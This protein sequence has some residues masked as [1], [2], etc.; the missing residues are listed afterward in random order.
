MTPEWTWPYF[1][2]N[3]TGPWLSD[4]KFQSSVAHGRR[5]PNSKLDA[6]SRDHDTAYALSKTDAQRRKADRV[7]YRKTRDMSW[8][9]RLAG[10]IVLYGND[11]LLLLGLDRFPGAGSRSKVG[12]GINMGND[13]SRDV[14]EGEN[15]WTPKNHKNLREIMMDREGGRESMR[16]Y[17]EQTAPIC[18]ALPTVN[19]NG[20]TLIYEPG[21]STVV[22]PPPQ[23]RTM[24]YEPSGEMQDADPTYNRII[25]AN[26]RR[27]KRR[28]RPLF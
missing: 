20:D 5:K 6:L 28:K 22:N 10:N 16:N 1:Q 3:Y 2:E 25:A 26:A 18:E 21:R 8:F 13:S 9:P 19:P 24:V 27:R 15:Q 14:V 7:Y 17:S 11:P 4:G 12:G 23:N